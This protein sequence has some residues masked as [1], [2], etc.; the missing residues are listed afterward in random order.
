MD[1]QGVQSTFLRQL[2]PVEEDRRE[3]RKDSN[4]LLRSLKQ[5]M[6]YP[7]FTGKNYL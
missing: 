3:I 1:F 4:V 2:V 7:C 6:E 5:D